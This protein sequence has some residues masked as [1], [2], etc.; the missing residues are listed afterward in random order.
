MI[1]Q[2][3]P[4]VAILGLGTMGL[5]MALC[6]AEITTV[7]CF[8]VSD[9]RMALARE[10]GLQSFNTAIETARSSEVVLLVVRD[11]EQLNQVLFGDNGVAAVLSPGS[12]VMVASTVGI[13][14]VRDIAERLEEFGIEIVDSPLSGGPAR[15]RLGDLLIVIGA[16]PKSLAKVQ[17]LV[18]QLGSTVSV[19]GDK[20]GDGQAL[21]TVNQLLCGVQ[22]AAAG[23]ALALAQSLGL[24]LPRTLAALNEGAAASFM[25][26]DRGAR[27]LEIVSNGS[28]DVLS[29]IDIFVKDLGIVTATSRSMKTP[30]PVAAAA[31]QLFMLASAQGLGELDDSSVMQ[32]LLRQ[33]AT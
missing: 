30:T 25:L 14:V 27:M 9:E 11:G 22:I 1:A 28:T 2:K 10:S 33:S 17:S 26:A 18:D 24:D 32:L 16:A 13:K 12:V 23:E 19:V 8:D 6:L 21:K 3:T 5:Q 29:R 15:A 7:R 31:H 4:T 20:P